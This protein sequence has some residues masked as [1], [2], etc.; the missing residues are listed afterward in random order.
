MTIATRYLLA[1]LAALLVGGCAT[2]PLI[3]AT[4]PAAIPPVQS[5]DKGKTVTVWYGTNRAETDMPSD[6]ERYADNRGGKMEFGTASVFVPR[7]HQFGSTGSRNIVERFLLG[8]DRIVVQKIS[9]FAGADGFWG[10]V[11]ASLK[12]LDE[13]DRMALV[14]IHGFNVGFNEAAIRA[15]QLAV[16]LDIT[17]LP[18]F[19]SWPSL[20]SVA[21]YTADETSI[22]ASEEYLRQFL[23]GMANAAGT[24]RVH[25]IAHSMG[26]RGLLRALDKAIDRAELAVGMK[27]GQI[28]LAAPDVDQ[29]VFRRLAVAYPK[30]AARTTLYVS[31]EDRAVALSKGMHVF[32]RVG[33]PP[34]FVRT[35]QIETVEVKSN[36]GLFELGHGY[37]AEF[38]PVLYDIQSLIRS[39]STGTKYPRKPPA[40]FGS[41]RPDW[42]LEE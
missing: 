15:A 22:E 31:G 40:P 36:R 5:D 25:I 14:Y 11:S 13:K 10:S 33:Y 12:A 21:R 6:A 41:N 34:P 38:A 24:G 9:P 32:D 2:Q 7:Q 20:A 37:Y 18:A 19:F 23:I 26:N 8:D 4:G 28:F 16:D 1:A 42:V 30:I 3:T 35:P 17:G 29:E 27:F 39:G